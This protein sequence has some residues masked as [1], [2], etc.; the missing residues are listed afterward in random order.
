MLLCITVDFSSRRQVFSFKRALIGL[1]FFLYLEIAVFLVK[2]LLARPFSRL[3][4]P[5]SWPKG[6]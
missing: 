5:T 1:L 2:Q 3:L 6:R 4:F